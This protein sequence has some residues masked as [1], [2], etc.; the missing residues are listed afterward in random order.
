[1]IHWGGEKGSRAGALHLFNNTIIGKSNRTLFVVT[2]FADCRVYI[3]NNVF[4]G[5]GKLWNNVGYISGS[6]NWFSKKIIVPSSK[7]F[8]RK[9][10][11]PGFFKI[12]GIPFFPHAGSYLRNRGTRNIPFR[13][14]HMPNVN[15]K[16]KVLKR[17]ADGFIDIGAYE[18]FRISKK[19]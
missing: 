6:N 8:G 10:Y 1:M 12:L 4:I 16:K 9:G 15:F 7:F 17:P 2:Q 3:K 13:V 19:N 14:S 18:Y 11:N 5:S